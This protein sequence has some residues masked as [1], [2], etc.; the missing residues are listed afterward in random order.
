[1]GSSAI[2]SSATS[3]R[4]SSSPTSPSP[5]TL[6]AQFERHPGSVSCAMP[7]AAVSLRQLTVGGR[8]EQQE[9]PTSPAGYGGHAIP[10]TQRM[11]LLGLG[12]GS[13]WGPLHV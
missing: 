5:G 4:G 8:G 6:H 3:Q 7:A 2:T 13:R 11:G 9:L 12:G 1:M 10:S